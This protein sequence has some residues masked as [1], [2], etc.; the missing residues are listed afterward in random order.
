MIIIVFCD[1]IISVAEE[2]AGNGKSFPPFHKCFS[3]SYT[4]ADS[5]TLPTGTNLS[6]K[7]CNFFAGK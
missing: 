7:V 1:G 5:V 6:Q 3:D 2:L 4:V